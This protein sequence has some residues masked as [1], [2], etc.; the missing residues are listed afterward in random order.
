VKLKDFYEVAGTPRE[1]SKRSDR[2]EKD[3]NNIGCPK[4][5]PGKV[6][7]RFGVRQTPK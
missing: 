3:Q 5:I 4:I 1:F 6:E 7:Q 2:P